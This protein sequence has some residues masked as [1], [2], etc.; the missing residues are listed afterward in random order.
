M[1]D[2]TDCGGN[3]SEDMECHSS[4]EEAGGA[5][6]AAAGGAIG[7]AAAADQ[8]ALFIQYAELDYVAGAIAAG[9]GE[10]DDREACEHPS[11]VVEGSRCVCSAER[12]AGFYRRLFG[13]RGSSVWREVESCEGDRSRDTGCSGSRNAV[14]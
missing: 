6:E 12:G 7:C 11:R 3:P 4:G 1:C 13:H 14:A 2:G 9:A 8:S 10:G 5:G